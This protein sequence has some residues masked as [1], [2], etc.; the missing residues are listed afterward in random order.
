MA[1]FQIVAGDWGDRKKGEIRGHT[2]VIH[3]GAL[4]SEKFDTKVDVEKAELQTEEEI[5][6]LTWSRVFWLGIFSLGA[7]KDKSKFHFAVYLKDGRKFLGV[8]DRKTWLEL[9]KAV[10]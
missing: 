5:K 1:E 4:R 2:L 8:S 7:K 9:Q 10:F 3:T 6:K